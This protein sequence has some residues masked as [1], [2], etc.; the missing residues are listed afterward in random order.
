MSTSQ[1]NGAFSKSLGALAWLSLVVAVLAVAAIA[2]AGPGYQAHWWDLGFALGKMLKYGGY[3]ALGAGLA[4]V[5]LTL[6][7]LIRGPSRFL[8]PSVLALIVSGG[9]LYVMV[10][11]L[12]MAREVPLYSDLMGVKPVPPIHDITTD[13]KAP[14]QFEAVLELRR[15]DWQEPKNPPE[16]DPTQGKLQLAFEG[17]ADIKPAYFDAPPDAVFDRALKT[18]NALGWLVI[19]ADQE[20]GIIEASET[21]TWFG[22]TDDVVIRV[23]ETDDGR[24]RLDMRSESRIGVSDVGQNAKRI[25][26]FM[27]AVK[28]E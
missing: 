1:T 11:Q 24:T 28:A 6:V 4:A 25:R 23:S 19:R 2:A 22:F 17:Y 12:A 21:S 7:L 10:P 14:P 26:R 27:E 18:V 20:A 9:L 8:V 16:Y 15:T 5:L 3:G 13:T